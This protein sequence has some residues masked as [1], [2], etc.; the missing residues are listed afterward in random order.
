MREIKLVNLDNSTLVDDEDYNRIIEFSG[1]WRA[2]IEISGR[3]SGV[4]YSNIYLHRFILNIK[5]SSLQVDHRD[6]NVLNNQKYNLRLATCSQNC[7][8]K[9]KQNNRSSQ[10]KGVCWDKR[11]KSWKAYVMKNYNQYHIGYFE[12]E[13]E[14]GLAY[15]REAFILFGEYAKL[16]NI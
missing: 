2:N 6:L 8:N 3:V 10:F 14:A 5:N 7:A 16:N 15:N 11:R 12:S 1:I 4:M 9:V 13:L